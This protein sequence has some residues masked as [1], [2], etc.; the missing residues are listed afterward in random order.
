MLEVFHNTDHLSTVLRE[1]LKSPYQLA[2][3]G[4][5]NH[6]L[7]LEQM[8]SEQISATTRF[9]CRC[10]FFFDESP[11]GDDW[12]SVLVNEQD[13]TIKVGN[14]ALVETVYGSGPMYPKSV[15]TLPTFLKRRGAKPK[16]GQ[17]YEN[18]LT[19][20]LMTWDQMEKF[21]Q[22]FGQVLGDDLALEY[23]PEIVIPRAVIPPSEFHRTSL[24]G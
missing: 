8:D 3:E 9:L 4:R 13:D 15:M 18:P 10:V 19:A 21:R 16:P 1:G 17:D 20:R 6:Y 12:V 23:K 5:G 24:T 2:L 22:K 14:I 7:S 11:R